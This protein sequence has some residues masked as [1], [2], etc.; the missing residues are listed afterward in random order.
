MRSRVL[1]RPSV[2]RITQSEGDAKDGDDDD[3][4]DD[5]EKWE[6]KFVRFSA[7]F[8]FVSHPFVRVYFLEETDHCTTAHRHPVDEL[9]P[10][11]SEPDL[12]QLEQRLLCW[13]YA[14]IYCPVRLL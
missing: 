9:I 6:H 4:D 5:E 11:S 1:G 8:S 7:Y 3:D 13:L 10:F 2:P 12:A 14:E